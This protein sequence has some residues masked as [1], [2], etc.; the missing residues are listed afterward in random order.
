[1]K[2]ND[3]LDIDLDNLDLITEGQSKKDLIRTLFVMGAVTV[4][5][6]LAVNILHMK[7]KED[8]EKEVKKLEE[9]MEDMCDDYV[10]QD[11]ETGNYIHK[12]DILKK[13][14]YVP[15]L[16]LPITTIAEGDL[17]KEL[18]KAKGV[19]FEDPFKAKSKSRKKWKEQRRKKK[20]Y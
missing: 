10:F 8:R 1:M 19:S 15:D 17:F 6:S 14:I 9:D 13:K 18:G 16:D 12:D 20:Y 4:S 2:M 3:P 7:S 11:V 5:A